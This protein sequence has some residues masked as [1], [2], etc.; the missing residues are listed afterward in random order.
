MVCNLKSMDDHVDMDFYI[1][2]Q[3]L[4]GDLRVVIVSFFDLVG[5]DYCRDL[6]H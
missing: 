6:F 3:G 4:E 5:S 2:P 1:L